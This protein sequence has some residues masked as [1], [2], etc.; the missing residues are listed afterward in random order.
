MENGWER[1]TMTDGNPG[2]G[3][4]WAGIVTEAYAAETRPPLTQ[5]LAEQV[6][7]ALADALQAEPAD[8][9]EALNAALDAFERELRSVVGPRVRTLDASA[10]TVAMEHRSEAGQPLRAF[11]GQ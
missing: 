7:S 1:A 5:D 4:D 3:V 8:R 2:S 6:R 10:G 11:V 9:A